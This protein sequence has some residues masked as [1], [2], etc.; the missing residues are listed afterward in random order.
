MSESE[1]VD[2]GYEQ[3]SESEGAE[4]DLDDNRESGK[5]DNTTI[6]ELTTLGYA[7]Y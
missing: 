4:D 1:L 2:Y 6:D 7:D 5:E 3:E